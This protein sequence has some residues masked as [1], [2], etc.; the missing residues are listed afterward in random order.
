MPVKEKTPNKSYEHKAV[1][2]SGKMITQPW[3]LGA[4]S[5]LAYNIS[6]GETKLR[7]QNTLGQK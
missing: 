6:R 3:L 5:V 1:Q 4:A 2:V 7:K